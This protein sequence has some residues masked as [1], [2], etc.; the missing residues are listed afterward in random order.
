IK[1]GARRASH[2]ETLHQWLIA[3]MTTAHREPVAIRKRRQVVRMRRIHDETDYSRA[4][5]L[6]SDDAEPFNFSHSIQRIAR[7]ID[8]VLKDFPT[9]NSFQIIDRCGETDRA[10]NV[11]RAGFET[12]GRFF[13]RTF[14][15]RNVN[16]HLT[17]AVPRRSGLE[18]FAATIKSAD[19]GGRAHFVTGER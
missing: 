18:D 10:G 19:A 7:K 8:I 17:A 1:A 14:F 3:M 12:M 11:R 9:P 16:D 2:A 5:F 13:V 4:I 15:E 6:R